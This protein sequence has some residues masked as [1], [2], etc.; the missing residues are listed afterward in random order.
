M[1]P[2]MQDHFPLDGYDPRAPVTEGTFAALLAGLALPKAWAL[3]S[4][5]IRHAKRAAS[6]VNTASS[7]LGSGKKAIGLAKSGYGFAKGAYSYVPML[8]PSARKSAYY[9]AKQGRRIPRTS[10]TRTA[11]QRKSAGVRKS[12][13]SA[14]KPRTSYSLHGVYRKR[15]YRKRKRK[16]RKKRKY[17]RR[18]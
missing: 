14:F 16:Y 12:G 2:R 4:S 9:D 8:S 1:P 11:P 10:G 13:R 6:H 18:R 17:R 15:K 7:L 5:S 3:G